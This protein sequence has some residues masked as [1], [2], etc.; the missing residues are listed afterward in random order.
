MLKIAHRGY[1]YKYKDN[2]IEAFIGAIEEG[3]DMIELDIQ[4]CKDDEII[5]FHDIMIHDREIKNMTLIELEEIGIIS[6]NTFFKLVD[7]LFI[8]VYLDLKGSDRIAEKLIEFIHTNSKDIYL[9]NIL[10]ASFNRNMLHIIKKSNIHVRLG[11][12]TNSNY[13]EHEWNMLTYIVDFVSISLEQLNHETL[14]YLHTLKKH[15]FAYTCHN[16]NELKYIQQFN[17]D[18]I[19]SNIVIE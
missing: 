1:S 10:I 12:I 7:T 8:E 15:V 4:L 19:V 18:G 11:Y 6:L 5:I 17:I 16:F 13:T 14:N 9:P 3:F 2:S